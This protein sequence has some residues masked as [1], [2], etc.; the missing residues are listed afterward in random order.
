MNSDPLEGWLVDD[1]RTEMAQMS[2]PPFLYKYRAV[3]AAEKDRVPL[4]RLL[5]HSELWMA[6]SSELNDEFEGA[7][8]YQVPE[9]EGARKLLFQRLFERRAGAHAA[10][11]LARIPDHFYAD[12]ERM[13][14]LLSSVHSL[15]QKELG[16]CSLTE[17]PL[18]RLMWSHYA[19]SSRGVCIQL[20]VS[21][22]ALLLTAMQVSYSD[23]MPVITRALEPEPLDEAVVAMTHKSAAW[24]YEK[25]W[26]AFELG[27][28]DVAVELPFSAVA[29]VILGSKISVPGR[30]CVLAMIE[31]RRRTCGVVPAVYQAIR[32]RDEFSYTM[33]RLL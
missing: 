16:V 14:E 6:D 30:A 23:E 19:D 27:R 3:P 33:E 20:D 18:N 11:L 31:Q 26:R 32:S 21:Q 1:R 24:K 8:A 4:E 7:A 28:S 25:E 10:E 5:V 17:D 2:I 15:V 9:E 22:S 13:I 12:K 29:G